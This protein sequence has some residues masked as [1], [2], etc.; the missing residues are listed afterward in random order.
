[1]SMIDDPRKP[2][3]SATLPPWGGLLLG[4]AEAPDAP[5]LIDTAGYDEELDCQC[6]LHRRA[7]GGAE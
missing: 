6:P 7:R 1:M 5:H 3:P 2:A 4:D